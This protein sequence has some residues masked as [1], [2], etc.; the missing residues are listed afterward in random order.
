MKLEFLPAYSPDYNPIEQA[1]SVLK[2]RI[3]HEGPIARD[4]ILND[5]GM[6][7]QLYYLVHSITP[8]DAQGFF[9]NSEY[10]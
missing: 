3:Q 2:S 1:F 5:Y 10:I 4:G 7:E 8:Q 6:Y 9:H